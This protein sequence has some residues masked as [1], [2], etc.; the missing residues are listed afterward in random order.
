MRWSSEYSKSFGEKNIKTN[1]SYQVMYNIINAGFELKVN[2]PTLGNSAGAITTAIAGDGFTRS[3]YCQVL[4][5][6]GEEVKSFNS[7]LPVTA[8]ATAE[9]DGDSTLESATLQFENGHATV[10]IT[11]TGTW[12][13][14]DVCTFTL[15]STSKIA[16]VSVDDKTSVDTLVA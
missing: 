10:I 1:D 11:Y 14:E 5:A 15:G 9:G 7:A 2:I 8:V 16:G 13:D 12:A 6:D 3:L 4:D